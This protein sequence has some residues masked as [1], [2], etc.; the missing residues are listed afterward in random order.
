MN[1]IKPLLREGASKEN[2]GCQGSV[3][4][5]VPCGDL[6]AVEFWKRVTSCLKWAL[7]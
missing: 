6:V 4:S 7:L 3:M 5:W 1:K 2:Y